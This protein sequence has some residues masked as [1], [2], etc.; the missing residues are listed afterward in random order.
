MTPE[1]TLQKF[2]DTAVAAANPSLCLPPYLPEP[3]KGQTLIIGAG[4]A[5]ALMA[6]SIESQWRD[7]L[8]GLVITRYGYNRPCKNIDVVE[9][10][11]PV[12]DQAGLDAAKHMIKLVSHLG[13]DD[14]C[15]ALISGGASSLLTLPAEGLTLADKQE[16]N[17]ALLQSGATI[18]D[19]NCLRKHLSAI[20]GGQLAAQIAPARLV[21]LLISDVPGDDPGVIG[22][23]P[24]VPDP[25]TFDDARSITNRFN[26]TLPNSVEKHLENCVRETPKPGDPIFQNS[27]VHVIARPAA[28]LEAVEKKAHEIGLNVLVLGDTLEGRAHEVAKEH[29]QLALSIRDGSGPVATP[30]LIISGGELT[31]KILGSG[32]GGPNTEYM[33]AMAIALNGTDR[34]HAIAC[35]TDGIDGTE[36]NAGAQI[37]PN[38]LQRAEIAG[39]NPLSHL[40][41]NDSYSFFKA[42]NDLIITGPTYT[43]VNDFRA[44]LVLSQ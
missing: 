33:L 9:A 43:N 42:I 41:N 2:F 1:Q 24:T 44:I 16:V 20:K 5:S 8:S 29:A 31:V 39:V 6:Q 22:S 25:T 18:S 7:A 35:D 3:P 28:S 21:T 10:A 12:P 40:T 38:T 19:M 15:I 4:K 26:I 23:G 34:I 13:P 14:L 27:E 32:C 37:S 30:A 36:D 11:H 17:R